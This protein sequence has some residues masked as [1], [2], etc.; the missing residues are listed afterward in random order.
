MKGHL[1]LRLIFVLQIILLLIDRKFR[2]TAEIF[3]LGY[4]TGS[5]RRADNLDYSR[6]GKRSYFEI[7]FATG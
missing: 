7:Y 3:T 6:P 4:L 5:Q 2:V 1:Q